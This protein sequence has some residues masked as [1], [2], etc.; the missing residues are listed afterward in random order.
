MQL[1]EWTV[2]WVVL[3]AAYALLVVAAT[4]PGIGYTAAGDSYDLNSFLWWP[5]GLG[6]GYPTAGNAAAYVVGWLLVSFFAAVA[7]VLL[8]RF[9]FAV[10]RAR[11]TKK[12]PAKDQG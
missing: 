8:V 10:W 11:A 5:G 3:V 4:T 9:L 7:S 6:A 12:S 2:F 1:R